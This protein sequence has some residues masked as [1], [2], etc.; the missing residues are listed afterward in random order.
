MIVLKSATFVSFICPGNDREVGK[1]QPQF[2]CRRFK[3]IVIRMN[4][5]VLAV[6]PVADHTFEAS[7]FNIR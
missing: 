7:R 1:F 5:T 3:K 2:I 6:G 4:T